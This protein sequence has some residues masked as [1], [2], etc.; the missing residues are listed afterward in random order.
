MVEAVADIDVEPR[1]A[2]DRQF[3]E[4]GSARFA[5]LLERLDDVV[6]RCALP[7]NAIDTQFNGPLGEFSKFVVGT[8]DLGLHARNHARHGLL[9]DLREGL[10]AEVEEGHIGAV[11]EQQKLEMVVPHPEVAFQGFLVDIEEIVV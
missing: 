6:R 2:G 7:K 9:A 10:F 8:K 5:E 11:T 3:L 4:P 1:V